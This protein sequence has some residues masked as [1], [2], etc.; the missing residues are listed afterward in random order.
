MDIALVLPGVNTLV[1]IVPYADI[2]INAPDLLI[3]KDLLT[4]VIVSLFSNRVAAPDDDIDGVDRMGWWGDSYA[5][6]NGDKIGSRLWELARSKQTQDTLN[7]AQQ[8]C[9]EALQWLVDDGVAES[10]TVETANNGDAILAIAV[11]I[12]KPTGTSTFNFQYVWEQL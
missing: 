5:T 4:A 8:Y 3:D 7:R 12:Y 9:V 11:N 6:V 10:F 1:N 2:Q